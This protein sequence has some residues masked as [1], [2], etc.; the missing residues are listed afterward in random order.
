MSRKNSLHYIGSQDNNNFNLFR[1]D[2]SSWVEFWV[3]FHVLVAKTSTCPDSCYVSIYLF[4]ALYDHNPLA[5]QTDQ[6][7]SCS[8]HKR[9]VA[10]KL[11]LY[12]I[13]QW[14][15][16]HYSC[17]W[18]VRPIANYIKFFLISLQQASKSE[19]FKRGKRE[20]FSESV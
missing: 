19:L 9:D 2:W 7:T 18:C 17:A 12:F 1:M 6:Q 16:R 3:G 13:D 10:L 15:Q 14:M 11:D 5:L 8:Q 20:F 4:V